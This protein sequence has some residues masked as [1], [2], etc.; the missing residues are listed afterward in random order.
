MII[1]YIYCHNLT[2]KPLHDTQNSFRK[3]IK[4][5]SKNS[6][7]EYPGKE[8]SVPVVDEFLE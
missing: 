4:E 3:R 8:K 7:L 1:D 6:D 5:V 2:I